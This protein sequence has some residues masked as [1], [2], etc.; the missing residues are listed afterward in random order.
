MIY[1]TDFLHKLDEQVNKVVYARITSLDFNELPQDT[2]E[3][4]I[5]SGSINLDGSSAV[6]RTCQL[7]L[8]SQELNII[9]YYWG[10]K[11]KIKVEIGVENQFDNT[12]P[13]IIWFDQGIYLITS[14]NTSYSINSYTINISGKDKMCLLNGEIAGTLNSSVDF[15]SI[16]QEVTKG[17]WRKVKYPIKD[18]I[19]EA[20][21]TYAGEPFHNIII[22]DLD[23]IGLELQEY[24]YDTP[25]YIWR[26][27]GSNEYKQGTLNGNQEVTY[28]KY[29]KVQLQSLESKGFTF[30]SLIEEFD[31]VTIK[32]SEAIIGDQNV[33]IARIQ[34][35]DTAGYKE[36]DL[37]YPDDLI[38]NIGETITSVL[39]KIKNFL[40]DF[41]YF[42]N[43][44]GQFVFQKKKT[45]VNTAWTPVVTDG[46]GQIYVSNEEEGGYAY[47]FADTKFFTAINNTPTLNN[48][49]N[50]FTVWGTR[51]SITGKDLPIHMR[52]ALDS[53]PIKYNTINVADDELVNYNLK[54][55]VNLTGQKSKLYIASDKFLNGDKECQCDWRELIYR[56]AL[57]YRKYNHLDNFSQKI[58]DAN[59]E[60]YSSGRTNYEQY[61]VDMEGFWREL[62]NPF[63]P[64]EEY[65]SN[66][67]DVLFGW[68]R[69]IYEYPEQL[70]FWFDFMD[71][72]GELSN[73]TVPVLGARPKVENDKDV[74]AIYYRSTPNI[75]FGSVQNQAQT[76]YRYFNIGGKEAMFKRSAKGKSAKDAI[77]TLLY[78]YSYCIESISITSIPIYYLQPNT[79]IY[80]ND[81]E[82][83]IEGVYIISKISLP[84]AYNGTMS[85]TAT[86]AVD[87][88]L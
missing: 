8:V 11:T 42:Y 35:G 39:D 83:G 1:D 62:Y 64:S 76:G 51:K 20:V 75:I 21:H 68:A 3:G 77:D 24:R 84:L 80:I 41:E 33:Y 45:Y 15:G 81:V 37:V 69:A 26:E 70:N 25:M 28:G 22:S 36:I 31:M 30:D 32:P 2:L 10:L 74:K 60:L 72:S 59:P 48:L 44:D 61:Y 87:R 29:G 9:N 38:A 34:Y 27:V 40:G 86:K 43:L 6:R 12:Q 56:M 58:A 53:K 73:F 63:D 52:Y 5:T 66:P 49:R 54:Y 82:S 47:S 57:D 78:N 4:R 50:D 65:Y 46:D 14:F 67:E 17:V 16:E 18:I 79:R 71:V 55:S 88:I 85:I 7:S 23:D 19:R 13:D